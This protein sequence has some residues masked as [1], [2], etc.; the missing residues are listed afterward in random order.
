M[1]I[2]M[3]KAEV[4]LRKLKTKMKDGFIELLCWGGLRWRRLPEEDF[5]G[6]A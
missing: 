1:M 4:E 3:S 6:V 2:E 5:E